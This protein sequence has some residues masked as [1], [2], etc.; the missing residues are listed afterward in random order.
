MTTDSGTGGSDQPAERS[1]ATEPRCAH[2]GALLAAGIGWC[3]QCYTPIVPP[4]AEQP[5]EAPSSRAS[6]ASEVTV[7]TS[8]T[9]TEAEPGTG[10]VHPDT[11]ITA[12][13]SGDGAA[14]TETPERGPLVRGAPDAGTVA[15][16][17]QM[18]AILAIQATPGTGSSRAPLTSAASLLSNTGAKIGVI[19]AGTVVLTLV[20]FGLLVLLGQML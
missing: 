6:G 10:P 13:W 1:S 14:D 8:G 20:G 11:L 18:L 19:V 5:V 16:A 12:A 4:Q 7:A 9:G 2:C 17:D 3:A 15:K